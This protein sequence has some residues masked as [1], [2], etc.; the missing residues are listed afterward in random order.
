MHFDRAFWPCGRTA[1]NEIVLALGTK[2]TSLLAMQHFPQSMRCRDLYLQ[3]PF[4]RYFIEQKSPQ[5]WSK[6]A[7]WLTTHKVH[8]R[9]RHRT[10][11]CTFAHSCILRHGQN[12]CAHLHTEWHAQSP[13]SGVECG[14]Q[15][16]T[17]RLCSLD[18][19]GKM[20]ASVGA[21]MEVRL[22]F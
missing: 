14:Q 10:L 3:Q 20:L 9:H 11:I 6:L 18:D 7:T 13:Y 1:Q 12:P 21:V 22:C 5:E 19:T 16:Q 15:R 2:S 17:G 8:N 4:P